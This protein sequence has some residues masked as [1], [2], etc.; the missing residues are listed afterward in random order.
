[1]VCQLQNAYGSCIKFYISFQWLKELSLC[2]ES[3]VQRTFTNTFSIGR[4]ML[5]W[6]S[7]ICTFS[8]STITYTKVISILYLDQ[9][10]KTISF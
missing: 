6:F 8:N 1:M 9:M 2:K 5:E 7:T 10:E 3:F 4:T